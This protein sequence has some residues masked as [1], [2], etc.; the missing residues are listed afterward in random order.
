VTM[1]AATGAT[2][3]TSEIKQNLNVRA[4]LSSA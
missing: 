3:N 4:L 1:A 2:I